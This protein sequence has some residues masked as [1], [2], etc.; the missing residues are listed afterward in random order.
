LNNEEP[1]DLCFS[2]DQ[3]NQITE[4]KTGRACGTCGVVQMNYANCSLMGKPEGMRW[5]GRSAC[6]WEDNIII[7]L[8]K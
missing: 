7:Y 8:K 1:H 3:N 6:T 4:D 2:P 5:L